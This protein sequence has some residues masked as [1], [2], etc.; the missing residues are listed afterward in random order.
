MSVLKFSDGSIVHEDGSRN[1]NSKF[2]VSLIKFTK[3][4][5]LWFLLLIWFIVL[6][7]EGEIALILCPL[8]EVWDVEPGCAKV[9]IQHIRHNREMV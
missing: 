7:G 9:F 4:V 5:F 8:K 3:S 6:H 1:S 2:L